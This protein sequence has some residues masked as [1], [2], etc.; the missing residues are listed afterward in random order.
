[1]NRED[2]VNPTCDRT[3]DAVKF[4]NF[5]DLTPLLAVLEGF[6]RESWRHRHSPEA[7]LPPPG[8][9]RAE[10]IPIPDRALEAP[11]RQNP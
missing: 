6:Y 8:L 11:G 4:L 1:M 7:V 2:F 3:V 5:L 9:I 10:E